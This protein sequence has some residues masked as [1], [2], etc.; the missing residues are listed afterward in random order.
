MRDC[1][2]HIRELD[3]GQDCCS[4]ISS[5][6]VSWRQ[7]QQQQQQQLVPHTWPPDFF[8]GGGGGKIGRPHF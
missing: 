8:Q 1:E 7:Q 4:R 3:P 6:S 2:K 5:N